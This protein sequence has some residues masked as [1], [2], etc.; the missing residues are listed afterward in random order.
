MSHAGKVAATATGA[1]LT[2]L[3]RPD[4]AVLCAIGALAGAATLL[5]AWVLS[6]QARSDRAT[7]LISAWRGASTP[8][9][10]PTQTTPATRHPAAS[11]TRPETA[12]Q[13]ASRGPLPYAS[14]INNN[15]GSCQ[16]RLLRGESLQ[17]AYP[18]ARHSAF[19]SAQ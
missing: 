10:E 4:S 8:A 1:I 15:E 16:A 11:A 12:T 7:T 14:E 18:K 5:L 2:A 3:A 13:T 19:T 6:D 17:D 9:L